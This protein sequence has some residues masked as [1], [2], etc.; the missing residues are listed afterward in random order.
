MGDDKKFFIE[1]KLASNTWVPIEEISFE[2]QKYASG[3]VSLAEANTA[4]RTI[5]NYLKVYEPH[6]KC[7]I[8]IIEL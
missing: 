3:F 2:F 5:K 4:K 1:A 8:R 7:P 6:N